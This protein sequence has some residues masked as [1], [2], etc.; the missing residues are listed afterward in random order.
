MDVRKEFITTYSEKPSIT[1]IYVFQE[2]DKYT[3]LSNNI[4]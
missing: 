3:K 4:W 2:R 1:V